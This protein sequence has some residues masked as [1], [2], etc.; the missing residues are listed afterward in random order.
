MQP[1]VLGPNMPAMFYRGDGRIDRLRGTAGHADRPEDWIGSVTAR[2]GTAD[3]GMTRLPDGSLLASAVAA[4]PVA[5]LGAAHVAR[6]GSDT[7]LLVKLL[8]AGQRLPVHVH[9]DRRFAAEHLARPHGKTEAW[10]VLEAAPDAAVYLGFN[11]DV[12]ADELAGWARSQDVSSLLAAT[13]RVPVA[14]GDSVLCPAGTPHAISAGILLVEL[15]EPADLS[16]MME[17]SSFGLGPGEATLGL[18]LSLALD[19]V[20]RRAVPP[21]RLES[22][23]GRAL[24]SGAG[25]L[26]PAE[27][28]PF[29][30]AERV[31]TRVSSFLSQSYGVLVVTAGQGAL[32]FSGG[33]VAVP[34][35][36]GSTVLIP[37]AAGPVRLGGAL[38]GVRC[39]PAV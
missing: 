10:I 22:L 21:S 12:G 28:D 25:S 38:E 30:V 2:F 24:N 18:P 8:D 15:Q 5:W 17:W 3:D 19:C 20:D 9:P 13:N 1:I 4:D 29:F 39:L 32:G 6:Y 34:V 11:R 37:H 36:R 7:G 33:G 27:G 16:I 26:L 35:A 14:A 31:D 23:R